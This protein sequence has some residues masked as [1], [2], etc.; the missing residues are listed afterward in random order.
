MT[1]Y[2]SSLTVSRA[3]NSSDHLAGFECPAVSFPPEEKSA[4]KKKNQTVIQHDGQRER[5]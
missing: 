4:R 2:K 1:I 5:I 3:Q